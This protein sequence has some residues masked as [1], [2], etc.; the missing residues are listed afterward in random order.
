MT[1]ETSIAEP[2][3]TASEDPLLA[4]L[5]WVV[6][7]LNGGDVDAVEY[8]AHVDQAFLA[9]VPYETA[10]VPR[11][12]EIRA[13]GPYEEVDI[14]SQ[15]AREVTAIVEA[16]DTSKLLLIIGVDAEDHIT[17]LEVQ[18]AELPT[19]D[20][21]PQTLE[22]SAAQLGEHGKASLLAAEVV[23]RELP[24]HI[25]GRERPSGTARLHLQVVCAGGVGRCG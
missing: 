6:D 25:R 10:F 7:L 11:L 9:A 20:D 8:E 14:V 16:A 4:Q 1:P 21:P 18:P 15:S 19:L 23:G 13:D 12:T 5:T 22:E 17:Y 2:T 3:T 24:A